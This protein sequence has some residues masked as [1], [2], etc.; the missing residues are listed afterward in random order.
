ME[1]FLC[2]YGH[3]NIDQIL[4]L[5]E[6]PERN[7][8]AN[9]LS[10]KS[11][12]GGTG[13]NVATMASALGVP[14]ALVSYV[15]KDL[16]PAF[17]E[18]MVSKGVILDELV[19]VEGEE[20]PTV[21]IATDDREDQVAYVYQG[22]MAGMG[23]YPLQVKAAKEALAVHLM[24]GSPDYYL[25]LLSQPF[26][27][28]KKKSLDPAQEIHHVW[29]QAKFVKALGSSD[30][31]FCNRSEL[32]TALRYIGKENPENLLTHIPVVVSTLGA[33]GARI[34]T[35]NETVDVPAIKAKVLD[36]TGAGDAF[37]AGFYAGLYRGMGW[38]ECGALGCAAASY[39]ISSPGSLTNVPDWEMVRERAEPLL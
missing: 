35:R 30:V 34:M 32:A 21:W 25:R 8:S 3:T 14:T 15:G 23:S 26:M 19:E 28:R 4:R 17:R 1:P 5:K 11:F 31:F 6:L 20:T 7:T 27:L 16:P 24:T 39:A 29:D 12:F 22:A 33:K 2:V 10:K 13:A 37:R 18:L 9:V 38:L 36:P